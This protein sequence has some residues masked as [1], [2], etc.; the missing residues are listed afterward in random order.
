MLIITLDG[1]LGYNIKNEW[2]FAHEFE[3]CS[4][5]LFLWRTWNSGQVKQISMSLEPQGRV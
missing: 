2:D 1:D 4:D 5:F 3:V